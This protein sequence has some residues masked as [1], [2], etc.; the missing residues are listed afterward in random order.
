MVE[1]VPDTVGERVKRLDP[2]F[3][4]PTAPAVK[5][6]IAVAEWL[7]NDVTLKLDT[8][9]VDEVEDAH[10]LTLEE[11]DTNAE[12]EA[13]EVKVGFVEKLGEW[14]AVAVL[15]EVF[16]IDTDA[17]LL[18]EDVIVVE[19]E[20]KTVVGEIKEDV[21]RTEVGVIVD[22]FVSLVDAV[23]LEENVD[24]LDTSD[25]ALKNILRDW[26]PLSLLLKVK[27]VEA[28]EVKDENKLRDCVT[29]TVV[30]LVVVADNCA[31]LDCDEVEDGDV[32]WISLALIAEN[33]TT[34]DVDTTA[35]GVEV[36]ELL[37]VLEPVKEPV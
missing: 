14:E 29:V 34:D 16:V 28:E 1:N 24:T 26:I 10:A 17:V 18:C 35:V 7:K 37:S 31:W 8:P 23:V 22:V 11:R 27:L 15:F 36:K 21:V 13:E 9:V 3:A 4:P 6:L 33:D 5:V 20:F 32:D 19:I 2:V 12:R 30:E 25:V